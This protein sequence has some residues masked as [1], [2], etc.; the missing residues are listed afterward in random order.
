LERAL[1]LD[2]DFKPAQLVMVDVFIA[3]DRRP[4]AIALLERI[5]R[6]KKKGRIFSSR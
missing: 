5:T 2:P 3:E 6:T 4:E 1:T